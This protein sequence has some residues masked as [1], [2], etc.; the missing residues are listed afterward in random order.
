MDKTAQAKWTPIVGI[1]D[2]VEV[3][4]FPS[5]QIVP[6]PANHTIEIQMTNDKLQVDNI[7]FY[8]IFGQLVKSVPCAGESSKDVTRQGINISDL[9]AGIYVVKAGKKTV[10]LVVN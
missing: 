9:S 5:L 7:E 8:N 6:N 4:N 2:N 10:K 1:T 3:K